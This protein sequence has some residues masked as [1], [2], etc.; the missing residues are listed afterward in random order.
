[1]VAALVN[2]TRVIGLDLG[3]TKILGGIL[4]EHGRVLE[5]HEVH[6]PT[7]SQEA[8]LVAIEAVVD[9]L[10]S[11]EIAAVAVGVPSRIDSRTGR[12]MG[13]VN[14]PLADVD[15]R[16]RLRARFRRPTGVGNDANVATLGEWRA[17]AGRGTRD[18][19]MLTLGT[20][21]GGGVVIEGR[22]YHGWAELGHVVVQAFGE[23]CQG[24]CTGHG[25]LEAVASG[26]AADRAAQGL[27]GG[28]AGAEELVERAKAGEANARDALAAIGRLLGAGVG[29]LVN[30]FNPE[31]VVIGGGFGVAC[32]ELLLGPALEVARIEALAPAGERLRLVEAELG[33]DAGL[34]GAAFLALEAL[35]GS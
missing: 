26:T 19:V 15:L 3:G 17:G 23:R 1:M 30:V 10:F 35:D 25:H 8:L 18:M 29:T 11:E 2:G 7:D 31:L 14:I 12:V 13:S 34:I 21:V 24:T 4:D 9:Q 20:G 5:R 27:W 33:A 6:T 22:P 32:G 16:D 28:D